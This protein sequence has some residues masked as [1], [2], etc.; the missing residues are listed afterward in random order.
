MEERGRKK[1]NILLFSYEENGGGVEC[2]TSKT[3][4]NTNFK[5]YN[6]LYVLFARIFYSVSARLFYKL[7]CMEGV[8]FVWPLK[9]QPP[10]SWEGMKQSGMGKGKNLK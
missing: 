8:S 2:K 5:K 1:T 9:G 4:E 6:I 3:Y 7:Q 10:T